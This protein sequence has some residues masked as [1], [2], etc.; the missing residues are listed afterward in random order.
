MHLQR[1]SHL[2]VDAEVGISHLEVGVFFFFV[3]DQATKYAEAQALSGHMATFL[4]A[5]IDIGQEKLQFSRYLS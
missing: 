1:I 5:E 2:E 4:K 3:S